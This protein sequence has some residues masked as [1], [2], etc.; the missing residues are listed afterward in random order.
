MS[1]FIV[2]G[3]TQLETIVKV[4][5]LPIQ[6][7]P[8]TGERDT[9]YISA[10][11]DAFNESLALKWLG[12]DVEFMSVVGEKENLA[13]FNPAGREVTLSTEY[14]LPILKETPMEVLLYDVQR[15]K[16]HFEDL[17]DIRDAKY[18][19]TKAEPLIS[20]CDMVVLSNVNF[21]RPFIDIA[22]KQKKKLAVKIHSFTREKETYNEDFLNNANILYFNDDSI[23]EEPFGFIKEMREKYDP[24]IIIFGQGGKGVILFDKE[25]E[26]TVHYDAVKSSQIVNTAGAGNALF[27]CFLHYYQK[28]GDSK[29]AIHKALLFAANKIGYMG[30]SNGFMTEDQLEQWENLIWNPRG[31]L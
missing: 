24:D 29:T 5:E 31:T 3:I 13:I 30:T 26:I 14:I 22:L 18:D 6:Y 7:T 4:K 9:I 17:K 15:R 19:M 8:Y 10:G 16:Q 2:A 25:K 28:T 11:G 12:D 27:A 20:E 23:D 21:C 1:R